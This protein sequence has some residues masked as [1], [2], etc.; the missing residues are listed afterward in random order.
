MIVQLSDCHIGVDSWGRD[1]ADGLRAAA[2]SAR[3]LSD[4]PP[5]AVLLT[6]DIAHT[7]AA[8]EYAQARELLELLDAPLF[9]LP[10]NHDDRDE[11]RKHFAFP[12]T[13]R[14]DLSYAANLGPIRLVALDTQ[15]PGR[16]GGR[17]DK[18]RQAWLAATLDEAPGTPTLVAMHHPPI[19]TGVP[20]MDGASMPNDECEAFAAIVAANP[21]VPLIATGHVHRLVAATVG[22][23]A[24]LAIPSTTDQLALDFASPDFHR[25][26]EPPCLALHLLVE[27]RIVAHVVPVSGS[28]RLERLS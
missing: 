20:A 21:Q 25:V 27:G 7:G 10:G 24:L 2:S 1:P 12:D 17:F 28:A 13:G 26:D 14:A 23:C 4:R 8:A 19:R 9:A 6:G 11:L 15:D 18:A 5:D 3:V 16:D 22:G